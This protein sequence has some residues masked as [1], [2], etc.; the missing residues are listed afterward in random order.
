MRF[1]CENWIVDTDART[2]TSVKNNE[3]SDV[4]RLIPVIAP[5]QHRPDIVDELCQTRIWIFPKWTCERWS[6]WIIANNKTAY[7]FVIPE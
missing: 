3:V 7:S 1:Q 2:L 4:V 6:M 5:G